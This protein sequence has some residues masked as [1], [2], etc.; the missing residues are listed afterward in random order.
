[1]LL[2]SVVKQSKDEYDVNI[3]HMSE[4]VS[5]YRLCQLMIINCN[6]TVVLKIIMGMYK[7]V[8]SPCKL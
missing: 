4:V 1:M 7:V 3:V 2:N 8:S 5:R 6:D